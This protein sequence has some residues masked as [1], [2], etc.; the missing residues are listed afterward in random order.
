MP[1]S[2]PIKT[3]YHGTPPPLLPVLSYN[4][5]YDDYIGALQVSEV[6]SLGDDGPPARRIPPETPSQL[7]S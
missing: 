7:S 2:I 3:E 5:S 4:K 1:D 6:E